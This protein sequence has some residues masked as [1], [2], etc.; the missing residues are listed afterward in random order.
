[1]ESYIWKIKWLKWEI[2][3]DEL[4]DCRVALCRWDCSLRGL[5]L[6]EKHCIRLQ[7]LD[8]GMLICSLTH[9]PS[10]EMPNAS[11]APA[12]SVFRAVT[13][14]AA[15]LSI[16]SFVAGLCTDGEG[17][18]GGKCGKQFSEIAAP[19]LGNSLCSLSEAQFLLPS[20]IFSSPL[21]VQ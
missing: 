14:E 15:V 3:N 8:E 11:W 12:P 16:F 9:S 6:K 17:K 19:P 5:C 4:W 20:L 7:L 13:E 10:L 21:L 2:N 18:V 1:M